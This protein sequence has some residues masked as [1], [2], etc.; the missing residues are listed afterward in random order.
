MSSRRLAMRNALQ[1]I[2]RFKP[3]RQL[4]MALE[5]LERG[6]RAAER[7]AVIA[8]LARLLMQAAGVAIEESGNDGR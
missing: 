1:P 8:R 5:S 3:P 4:G 7:S 6:I 2:V